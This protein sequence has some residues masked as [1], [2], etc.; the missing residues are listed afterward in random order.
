MRTYKDHDPSGQQKRIST[1]MTEG[2]VQLAMDD[3]GDCK[4]RDAHAIRWVVDVPDG[5]T[6][7]W[8]RSSAI[9]PT[10]ST[11]SGA[12]QF[13]KSSQK[14]REGGVLAPFLALMPEWHA[15][16]G[17]VQ[18]LAPFRTNRSRNDVPALVLALLCRLCYLRNT[19]GNGSPNRRSQPWLKCSSIL[20]AP[21]KIRDAQIRNAQLREVPTAKID[22]QYGM[23]VPVNRRAQDLRRT[24]R[25]RACHEQPYR[26][27]WMKGGSEDDKAAKTVRTIDEY[28]RTSRGFSKLSTRN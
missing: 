22:S 13:G 9:S 8:N 1:N 21:E 7:N 11:R 19:S 27:P 20:A 10:P 18:I 15:C 23:D 2:R 28:L 26:S 5:R 3:S 6:A 25:D 14:R 24:G 17:H 12:K 16:L 4:T